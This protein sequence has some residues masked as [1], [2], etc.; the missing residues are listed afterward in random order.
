M[1]RRVMAWSILTADFRRRGFANA[2]QSTY[3]DKWIRCT[4]YCS[5]PNSVCVTNTVKSAG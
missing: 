2:R 1:S 5:G 4:F 3:R